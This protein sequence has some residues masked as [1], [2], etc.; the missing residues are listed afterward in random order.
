MNFDP[1]VVSQSVVPTS[2]GKRHSSYTDFEKIRRLTE[3]RI[4]SPTRR[5]KKVIQKSEEFSDL[6][7]RSIKQKNES[8]QAKVPTCCERIWAI[9]EA[10]MEYLGRH[11]MSN[12][13][14]MA[15]EFD[16]YP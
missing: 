16:L 13:P 15:M 4:E 12:P 7:A 8:Y 5:Y 3:E 1:M 14:Y 11:P 9:V 6:R 10:N 2:F